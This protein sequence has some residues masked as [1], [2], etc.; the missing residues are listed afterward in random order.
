MEGIA[1]TIAQLKGVMHWIYAKTYTVPTTIVIASIDRNAGQIFLLNIALF[2]LLAMTAGCSTLP[3]NPVPLKQMISAE[4]PSMPGIRAWS[5]TF[6]K[7]FETDLLHSVQQ[8]L[9][10]AG[11][12]ETMPATN[13]L[14]LSGGGDHGAF[15]AGVMVGW[16]QSGSRP[17]FKL[18]TGISTGALIAPFAFLG[19]DYDSRLKQ[20]A[21]TI[22][23]KDVYIARWFSFLW[24][25]AFADSTPLAKLIKRYID[26]DVLQAIAKAHRQGRR[27]YIGT[28]NLDAD[29]LVVWNMGVIANSGEPNA[30]KLF[31]QIILASSSIPGAFPPVFIKVEID[32]VSYDEMHVDGGIKAQLFVLAA[33]L[34]LAE[35]RK[36]LGLLAK[37][38]RKRRIF[39]IRNAEVGPEPKQ[40]PR[41]LAEISQRAVSSLIKA[42]A[43]NDLNRI[44]ELTR[45]QELDFNWIAIP[46]EYE[47]SNRDEFDT[48]EMNRLFKL[49]Y[50]MGLKGDAWLKV[51]PG[52]GKD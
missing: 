37:A 35:F 48:H 8:A 23:A 45:E 9:N 24:N 3:R 38:D 14:S 43:L 15:G 39:V 30:L 49:G 36:K 7:Q 11:S 13:I 26:K 16:S 18:V 10:N 44:Y 34:D 22:S 4:I 27:L 31:R 51:P 52:L 5:G 41:N 21:T 17:E 40:I 2:I 12:M 46:T 32:G 42:Q 29:R 1:S 28:T 19:S 50:D 33:T 6:S 25:D 20:F 47:P